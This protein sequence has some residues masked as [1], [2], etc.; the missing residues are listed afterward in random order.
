MA[1][2]AE[3]ARKHIPLV[4]AVIKLPEERHRSHYS[5]EGV[6]MNVQSPLIHYACSHDR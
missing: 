3:N 4:K 5:T 6:Q 1:E 2:A